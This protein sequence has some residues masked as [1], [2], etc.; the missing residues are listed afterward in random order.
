M[1]GDGKKN[2]YSHKG[3]GSTLHSDAQFE[4]FDLEPFIFAQETGIRVS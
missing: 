1:L 4:L 2:D 3:T